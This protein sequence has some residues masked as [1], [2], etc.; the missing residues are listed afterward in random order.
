MASRRLQGP[1]SFRQGLLVLLAFIVCY[2]A[3][4]AGHYIWI[5]HTVGF[6]NY[7]GDGPRMPPQLLIANQTIK[8]VALVAAVWLI[9]LRLFGLRWC[10]VGF[11]PIQQGWI[12]AGL[13][14]A[15]CA[16]ALG[17]I[18][19]KTMVAEVPA[20][21]TFGASRYALADLTILQLVGLTT[22]TVLLTPIAEEV[23][24]RGF[25]FQW[26]ATHRP[27]WL[28]ILASSI[29]F[30]VSHIVP[31]QVI[32]ASILSVFLIFL[33]LLSGSIWPSIVCH[34]ANNAIAL[35]LNLAATA[36][37]LPAYLTP[38]GS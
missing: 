12:I 5:K 2:T 11:R 6:E 31:P 24:F 22:L 4:S 30:G 21:A 20:W 19:V 3:L 36:G 10:V 14:L 26:M 33:Y 34:C 18:L 13:V 38:P 17:L 7:L 37:R 25:L 15:V 29:M 27:V 9:A 1:W 16:Q 32:F 28:A 35:S 23:F 8:I